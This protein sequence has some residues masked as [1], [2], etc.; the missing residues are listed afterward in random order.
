MSTVAQFP[1]NGIAVTLL[2]P[3]ID[4]LRRGAAGKSTTLKDNYR[5][6]H[7]KLEV[8]ALSTFLR[9]V[10]RNNSLPRTR[11]MMH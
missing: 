7:L 3:G 10:R 4:A 6:G 11:L 2:L 9:E 5:E 8:Y 1:Q